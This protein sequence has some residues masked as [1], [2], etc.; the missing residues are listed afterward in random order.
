[1]EHLF[2]ESIDHGIGLGIGGERMHLTYRQGE[3]VYSAVHHFHFVV[4]SLRVQPSLK[5]CFCN[6]NY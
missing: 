3:M 5:S 2:S 4:N 1:M 6:F